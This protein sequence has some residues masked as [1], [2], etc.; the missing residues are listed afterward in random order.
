MKEINDY[1]EVFEKIVQK[2]SEYLIN[3]NIKAQI[4]YKWWH[5]LNSLCCYMP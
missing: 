2:T 1:G 5:R 4:L 3:N